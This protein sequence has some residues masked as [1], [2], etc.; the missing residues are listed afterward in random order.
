[1]FTPSF[2]LSLNPCA[3]HV[4]AP[5]LLCFLNRQQQQRWWRPD[6]GAGE[7]SGLVSPVIS[8]RPWQ[9]DGIRARDTATRQGAVY[10]GPRQPLETAVAAAV[11]AA[12]AAASSLA[13]ATLVIMTGDAAD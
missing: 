6:C 9:Q 1:M 7:Q 3:F 10:N 8:I 2:N 11:A 5:L 12:A 4:C 13:A